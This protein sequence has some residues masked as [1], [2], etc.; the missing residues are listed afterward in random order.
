MHT[1]VIN[2]VALRLAGVAAV[3]D[4]E[5]V[6]RRT[7][8]TH[9]TPVRA[10]RS[11]DLVVIGVNF[12]RESDWLKNILAAQGCRMRLG[13]EVLELARPELVPVAR[14]T[15]HMPR[16]VGLVLRHVVR[17][18]D[19]VQLSVVGSVPAHPARPAQGGQ[20]GQVAPDARRSDPRTG[21]PSP[22]HTGDDGAR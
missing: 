9:H 13:D 4:L 5:H 16:V 10:Y 12:G 17:T 15:R 7:G 8:R 19:C 18:R 14:G 3:A 20:G 1:R 22:P 6:G 2:K 21:R 11:D